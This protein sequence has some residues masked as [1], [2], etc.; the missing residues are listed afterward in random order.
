MSKK[1]MAVPRQPTSAPVERENSEVQ[2]FIFSH[3]R[4][5]IAYD[6]STA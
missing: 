4:M 6:H 3:T 2:A 5:E 1:S